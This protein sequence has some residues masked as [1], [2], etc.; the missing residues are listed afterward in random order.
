MCEGGRLYAGIWI[1]QYQ[2]QTHTI[3]SVRCREAAQVGECW[4]NVDQFGNRP[5]LRATFRN[6][7]LRNHE[8]HAR[9]KIEKRHLS[10]GCVFPDLKSM[11]TDYHNDSVFREVESIQFIQ[12][13]A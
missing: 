5:G 7:G 2:L 12:H 8:W 9:I 10:P 3:H 1:P 4:I 11:V 13:L 6:T